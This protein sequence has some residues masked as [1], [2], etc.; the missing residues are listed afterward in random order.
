MTKF[1]TSFNF[2]FP[3]FNFTQFLGIKRSSEQLNE[4]SFEV[5]HFIDK[6]SYF[7]YFDES[8]DIRCQR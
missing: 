7:N 2:K 3:S 4:F 8:S 5:K 1:L 6:V